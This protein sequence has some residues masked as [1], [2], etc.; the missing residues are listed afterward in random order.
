[1][2]Y[3]E[4]ALKNEDAYLSGEGKA[5]KITYVAIDHTERY[6]DPEE[7]VRAEYWAEL[8]Y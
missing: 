8:I 5:E 2:T 7:K 4:N 1:M 6:A 3:L